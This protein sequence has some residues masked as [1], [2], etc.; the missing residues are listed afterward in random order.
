MAKILVIDDNIEFLELLRVLLEQRGGHQTIISA[1][2]TDGLFKALAD[3]P[4]LV[5]LDVMMPA[6]SGY[7]ICRQLRA[8]SSTASIPIIILTA[9]AQLVDHRAALD[10]GA[11]DHM[12]KPVDMEKL[13]RR[14][15][16][17][18]QEK[19]QKEPEETPSLTQTI[20]LSSLRGG[21]GVTTL[22]VNVAVTLA[23]ARGEAVC[24]V[25]L[26]SSSGH[27]ALQL[28]LRPE[29]NWS[30]LTQGDIPA[31]DAIESRLLQHKSGLRV[32]ASPVLPTVGPGLSKR[33]TLATMKALKQRF[34]I[35]IVDAPA[36]LNEAAMTALEIAKVVGL[37]VTAEPPSIQTAVGTLRALKQW[38]EKFHIILNQVA[39]GPQLPQEALE[40]ALKRP[41]VESILFDPAQARALAQGAPLA[42]SNPSSPLAQS[43]RA[44]GRQ[45]LAFGNQ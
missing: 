29:P 6:I 45:L 15:N 2:G 36:V 13:L 37:V 27:A 24:L 30:G 1:D 42:L 20:V 33:A 5:I 17:L 12:V 18:L 39:P 40:R 43:A 9:R 25:D 8:N 14:V 19:E 16:D 23:Q 3:P 35:I 28:G 21:V 4:D 32:L 10:A 31:G 41:L 11:D 44:L 34:P 26:S 22:A 7:E 38:S